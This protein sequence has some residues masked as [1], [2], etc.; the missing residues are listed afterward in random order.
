MK[1]GTIVKWSF[2][3]SFIITLIGAYLKITHAES[4]ETLLIIG[5]IVTMIFIVSAIYE[6]RTSERIDNTEKTMWTLAF[7][8][9]S[10]I[11]GLIYFL[12]GRKR[13]VTTI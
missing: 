8:F 2:I 7:I 11:T 4:A 1:L 12:I 3:I 10:G 5:V 9:F 13:I 6:V